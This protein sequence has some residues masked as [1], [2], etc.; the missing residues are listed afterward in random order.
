MP[1][2]KEMGKLIPFLNIQGRSKNIGREGKTYQKVP[3]E[4]VAIFS[5]LLVSPYSQIIPKTETKGREAMRLPSKGRRLETSEMITMI[6]AE[7]K[8][9]TPYQIIIFLYTLVFFLE[10]NGLGR[11][12][13]LYACLFESLVNLQVYP[14]AE[15]HVIPVGRRMIP[16]HAFEI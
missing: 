9:F 1:E 5:M 11:E 3:S 12:C 2:A 10:M 4:W 16:I 7:T 14:F 6:I 13:K 15:P 8:I